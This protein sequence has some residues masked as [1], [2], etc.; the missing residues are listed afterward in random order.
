MKKKERKKDYTKRG[1]KTILQRERNEKQKKERK[2][3][4]VRF[5]FFV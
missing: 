3:K 2:G 1:I 5:I 4:S